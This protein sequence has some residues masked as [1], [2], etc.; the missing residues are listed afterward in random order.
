[1]RSRGF[2]G[3]SLF[4]VGLCVAASI[5]V[6]GLFTLMDQPDDLGPAVRVT[7]LVSTEPSSEGPDEVTS[8]PGVP[9]SLPQEGR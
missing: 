6:W 3:V 4:I 8:V 2:V 9:T 1:M 7:P 5:A